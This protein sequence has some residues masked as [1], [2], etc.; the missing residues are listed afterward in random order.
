MTR[1]NVVSLSNFVIVVLKIG[2]LLVSMIVNLIII[3]HFY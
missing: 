2:R 1:V 3:F